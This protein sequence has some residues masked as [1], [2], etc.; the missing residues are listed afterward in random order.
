VFRDRLEAGE[1][2]AEQLLDHIGGEAI[3]LGIPRGG[4][5]VARPIAR[6]LGVPLDVA[7]P[8]KLGAP[9]NPELGIGAVAPG[10]RVLDEEL[11]AQLGISSDYI[12]AETERQLA[13]IDRRTRAYR[14]ERP[15][16]LLSGRT[17]VL[18]DDGV[19]TGS[20]A[21]AALAWARA[22]GGTRLVFAAPVAPEATAS[23]IA[24]ASDLTVILETPRSFRAVGEWY[25]RFDQMTDEEV[26]AALAAG[27]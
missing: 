14:G 8:R 21:L 1:R 7:V 4:I 13:E 16:P 19:A 9:L 3:V 6:A 17:V 18:V 2:L 12:G 11:I 22:A 20:T 5:A 26:R 24:S 15:P 10:V 23:R 27:V 25:E